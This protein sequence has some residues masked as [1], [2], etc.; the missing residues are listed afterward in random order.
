MMKLSLTALLALM[1]TSALAADDIVFADFEGPDYGSWKAEGEAFGTGPAAG[2]L[3]PQKPVTGFVGHGLVNSFLGGDQA[4]GKL[5]SP[6]FR[7]K[8]RHIT[9]LIGGGG[10]AGQTCLSLIVGGKAVRTATGPHTTSGGSEA[11]ARGS[12]DVSDLM[13]HEATLEIV[14]SA[15]GTWGHICVDQIVFTDLAPATAREGEL[16]YN[17]I[18]LP[19]EWP[20]RSTDPGSTQVR[21][22]P[23]LDHPPAVSSIDV[24]RQLFVDDFLIEKTD[25]HRTFHHA[26]PYEKNPI[27]FPQTPLELNGG[28]KPVAALFDDGVWFDPADRLFKLWYHA[29]WFTGTALATSRDGLAWDRPSLDVVPGTNRVIPSEGHGARDGCGVWLDSFTS[30]PAER[31]KMFLYERPAET[32]GGGVLTSPDGIHWTPRG[33]T[34][35]VGDNT[36]ISYNPFRKK[37]IYSVRHS[38]HGRARGY[39]ECDD[40]VQGAAWEAR[41]FFPWQHCDD[42]DLPDPQLGEAPQLYTFDTVAYESVMLGVFGVFYGPQNPEAEKNKAPKFNDLQLGYSRDGFHYSRPDR[43]AFLAATRHPGDW[44]RAY[45]HPAS[46][47]CAIVGDRLYF[48]YSAWSGLRPDGTGDMY[49]GGATGVAFLRRDGFAS[50]DA[51]PTTATLL[52]RPL[53][54]TGSHLFVNLDGGELRAEV[55]DERGQVVAPFSAANCVPVRGNSTRA[56]VRWT[57]AEDLSAVA[58][59]TVRLRFEVTA[60][61]FYALWVSPEASGASHGYVA[62]GGPEFEGP[63]DL[64]GASR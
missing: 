60:G 27:L 38:A 62:A 56:A 61:A 19:P 30:N 32:Y 6:P 2:T 52:T 46:S 8:R 23:Y 41:D 26:T 55:V 14:D 49:A 22:A 63:V 17:G 7:I 28:N 5:T 51:G 20:P 15:R 39:R 33:H 21:P 29:G 58:G 12:W 54:F 10:W 42:L 57:G 24:G 44:D 36:T 50:L 4:T 43:T 11:L 25:L 40:F 64:A 16:L 13:G 47:V 35:S 3:P 31:F 34:P 53:R 1:A 45:L 37:W 59:K 48:Y 9:F 18:Q